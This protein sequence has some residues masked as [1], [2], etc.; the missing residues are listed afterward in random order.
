M[1]EGVE[2]RVS[3]VYD[4]RDNA[5]RSLREIGSSAR[6]A[7]KHTIGLVD[8][9]KTVAAAVG[10]YAGF[11]KMKSLLVDYNNELE[12]SKTIIAGML[13]L[14]T[15]QDI[16][17]TWDRAAISVE[18]FQQMAAKSSLTTKDLVET[19]QGLTRPLIQ[20]GVKMDEIEKI[21]FGVANAAKAFGMA[22]SVVSMDIEQAIRGGVGERDRFM[23]S[24]LAQKGIELSAKEFN[25]KGQDERIKL[26]QKAL[27][28]PAISAMAEKQSGTMTGQLSTLEDNVQI[29]FGKIGLPLVR[30]ITTEVKGW[31]EWIEANGGRLEQMGKSFSSALIFGFKTVKQVVSDIW[32]VMQSFGGVLKDLIV[33]A[34]NHKDTLIGLAKSLIVLK[35]GEKIGGMARGMAGG[36][37][38]LFGGIGGSWGSMKDGFEGLKN[39]TGGLKDAFG[40]LGSVLTGAGGLIGAFAKLATLGYTLGGFLLRDNEEEKQQNA[41]AKA[42]VL[43]VDEFT[44][45]RDEIKRIQKSFSNLGFDP[46]DK[47]TQLNNQS[48]KD[49]VERLRELEANVYKTQA[50]LFEEGKAIGAVRETTDKSGVRQMELLNVGINGSNASSSNFRSVFKSH[51]ELMAALTEVFK[52]KALKARAEYGATMPGWMSPGGTWWGGINAGQ[53]AALLGVFSERVLGTKA[54]YEDGQAKPANQTINITIQRVMAKDPNKWLADMDDMVKQRQRS[55]TRAKDAWRSSPR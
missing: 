46:T 13:T 43:A 30:A 4:A 29:A 47:N 16:D 20:V 53:G 1:A 50:K 36:V 45:Q 55:Q 41:R 11:G 49:D 44:R 22:G 35:V 48:L 3:T 8:S 33:F 6:D 10:A 32:P 52:E 37:G 28:S 21:T 18:R 5:S 2:Y 17:K 24:M 27:T 40:N 38:G 34:A 42:Q 7:T 31:N 54:A 12:Q 14:Y 51:S 19:A 25:S 26:L 39:G 9:L 23:K 15:G